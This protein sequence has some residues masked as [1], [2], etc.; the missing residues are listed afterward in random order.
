M[1]RESPFAY[2]PALDGLRAFAVL[3][4]IAYHLGYP[5]TSRWA[6]GGYLGVDAFFV[7]SG[8]LITSL[9]LGEHRKRGHIELSAFWGRRARRLLPAVLLLVFVVAL[10]ARAWA[11]PSQLHSLRG[12]SLATLLYVA[13]WHFIGTHQSYFD[14]FASPS[15][16]RHMWSL[17][18][19]EQFYLVWPLVVFGV[20]RATRGRRAAL[21]GVTV[22]GIIASTVW[23]AVQYSAADPSRAYYGTD[24]RAHSLLVGCLLALLLERMP[25]FSERANRYVQVVGIVAAVGMLWAVHNI[26]DTSRNM[27]YGGFLLYA[28][29][30]ALV[31]MAAVQTAWSPL[32]ALFSIGPLRWIG[33]ISYGLYLWHWPAIVILTASRVHAQGNTLKLIQVAATFA[34]ATASFYLVERP[35]RYGSLTNRAVLTTAPVAIFAVAFVVVGATA[36]YQPPP[37]DLNASA[38]ITAPPPPPSTTTTTAP[39]VRPGKKLTSKPAKPVLRPMTIAVVGDSVAGTIEWGL[40]DI[41]NGTPVRIVNAAFPGCGVADGIALD[42]NDQ[43][44]PWSRV[45]ADNVPRVLHETVAE[46]HPDLVL[47]F[48]SWELSDRLDSA[49]NKVLKLGSPANDAALLSSVNSAAS[50]LTSQGAHLVIL[51]V[52]PRAPSDARPADG[53]DGRYAH[54]N[55]LLEQYAAAHA[56]QVSVIDL[57]PF[58]CASGPPCPEKVNGVVL[59]PDGEHFTHQTAPIIAKWLWPQLLALAPAKPVS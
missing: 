53:Q 3:A 40:D 13:N 25:V 11:D 31:V 7:I 33:Q 49:T 37:A 47:W 15:P 36:G 20:L 58:E 56:K 21:V 16:L 50:T 4:V 51:T 17:A 59:R 54:Y 18:I 9:L 57:M 23:M 39:R 19:E 30:V 44:F 29:A 55:Q 42:T 27:Y 48:S 41:A 52:P 35:I 6:P 26:T 22:T 32:R 10:Y 43:P 24:T 28:I 5:T 8:Y 34:V 46:Q 38:P 45:C 1:H 12:D 2:R 14:L